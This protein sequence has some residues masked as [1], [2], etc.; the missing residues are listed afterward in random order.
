MRRFGFA[1]LA[2]VS[3]GLLVAVRAGLHREAV[4]GESESEEREAGTVPSDWFVRQRE[5]PNP[6]IPAGAHS[7]SSTRDLRQSR[8]RFC[9][10]AKSLRCRSLSRP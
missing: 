5:F 9:V 8:P 7:A 10:R 1:V 6:A 2:L 4:E 3:I